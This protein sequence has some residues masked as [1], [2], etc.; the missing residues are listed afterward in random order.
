MARLPRYAD[1]MRIGLLGGT[2]NPPHDGHLL[3]SLHAIPRL[4][5]DRVWWLITPGNPLKDISGLPTSRERAELARKMTTDP[6]IDVTIFEDEIGTRYTAET[7]AWLK[8]RCPNVH[9][10]W[11]MGADNLAGFHHWRNWRDI[12]N[13]MPIAIFDRPQATLAASHSR[14]AIAFGKAR[15]READA[16][17][18]ATSTAPAWVF[19]HGKR[20]PLSSTALRQ[21]H[22][23]HGDPA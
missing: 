21:M 23:T 22:F 9:F 5:L 4:Q 8:N 17:C 7:L 3:I 19:F 18:L 1:G 11:M 15:K 14:A 20:S 10:V 12:A 13:I 2:F 6:R 16:A